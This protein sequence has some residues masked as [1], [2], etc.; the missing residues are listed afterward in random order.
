MYLDRSVRGIALASRLLFDSW[1][2]IT[3]VERHV[4][5]RVFPKLIDRIF[6]NELQISAFDVSSMTADR[7]FDR[8]KAFRPEALN[9]HPSALVLIASY[10]LENNLDGVIRPKAVF[11]W[12]RLLS[13]NIE[14]YSKGPFNVQFWLGMEPLN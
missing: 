7:I 11:P 4:D 8:I 9:G 10:V 6:L 2:G 5:I 1:V 14:R 3:P 12:G 13:H